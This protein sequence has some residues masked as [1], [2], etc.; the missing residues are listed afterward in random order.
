M[1]AEA[2][3]RFDART[4]PMAMQNLALEAMDLG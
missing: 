4:R 3:S 1:N 2:S